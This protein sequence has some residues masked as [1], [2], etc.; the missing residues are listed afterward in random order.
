MR[1]S[2]GSQ[3]YLHLGI[4]AVRQVGLDAGRGGTRGARTAHVPTVVTVMVMVVASRVVRVV[5]IVMIEM[6]WLRG[7][8]WTTPVGP[9]F[10][11][12]IAQPLVVTLELVAQQCILFGGMFLVVFKTADAV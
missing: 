9:L 1:A 3:S 12:E 11:L 10:L 2:V 8:R 5:V 4:L 7:R 6:W